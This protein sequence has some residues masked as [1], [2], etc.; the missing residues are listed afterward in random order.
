MRLLV[1]AKAAHIEK[2][3]MRNGHTTQNLHMCIGGC[4]HVDGIVVQK[5]H[6][7]TEAAKCSNSVKSRNKSTKP[8]I[9][10]MKPRNNSQALAK[11]FKCQSKSSNTLTSLYSVPRIQHHKRKLSLPQY[12]ISNVLECC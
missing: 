11:S 3:N 8:D 6:T 7:C 1:A 2:L 5:S 9:N 4:L 12:I 10:S